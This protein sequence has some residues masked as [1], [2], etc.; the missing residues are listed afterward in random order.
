MH[1]QPLDQI[2]N[3]AYRAMRLRA[4]HEHPGA[5]TASFEEDAQRPLAGTTQ[6]MT[7]PAELLWDAFD[8]P[9][10]TVMT[11]MR[12]EIRVKN[13]H[14]AHLVGMNVAKEHAG[15]GV[16]LGEQHIALQLITPTESPRD[17]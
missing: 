15:K 6:R 12:R 13:R 17:A 11:S 8:G 7:A 16:F 2:Q 14:K 1:L 4:L 9:L 5:F 3:R 10:L